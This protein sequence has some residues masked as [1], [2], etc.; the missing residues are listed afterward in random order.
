[1]PVLIP[2]FTF[3]NWKERGTG[4]FDS[5]PAPEE[6]FGEGT[7]RF[8]LITAD[9]T[10]N[11]PF[12]VG[13][14]SLRLNT[15]WRYQHALT[16]L[17]PQDRFSIGGRYTVRGFDGD[18]GL[19]AENGLLVRNELGWAVGQTGQ[20]LYLGLDYGRVNGPS[21][22]Y[23]LGKHLAGSVLGLRGS[24]WAWAKGLSYDIFVGMPVYKPTGFRTAS[25][26]GGFSMNWAF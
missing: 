14:Q 20:E 21:S 15:H 11:V 25:V 10:L 26:T 9:A 24:G 6:A 5:Q 13:S 3:E 2:Y 17:T 22:K 1:M 4:A 12:S 23:L 18:M 8:E 7:S 19:M 16:P